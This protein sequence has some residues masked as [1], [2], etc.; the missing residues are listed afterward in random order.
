MPTKRI[1]IALA[2]FSPVTGVTQ[3]PAFEVA[4]VRPVHGPRLLRG[5]SANLE[6]DRLDFSNVTLETCLMRAW[7]LRNYQIVV[8]P[9]IRTER[10][11]IVAKAPGRA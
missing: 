7:H 2:I 4:S 10:F 8:P 1:L 3:L 11:A 9:W 6:N 5:S